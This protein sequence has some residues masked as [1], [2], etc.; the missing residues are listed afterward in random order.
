VQTYNIFD[1]DESGIIN[2]LDAKDMYPQGHGDAWGHY[3][4]GMKIWYR[5]LRHE[6][7]TWE[8][9]V[10]SV[11]V[12][13]APIPV[14]Y[15]DERKFAETAAAK[16]KAGAEIVNLT[17]RLSYVDDPAGQWQGY[18]DTDTE[19]AWGVDGWARR[20]GQGAYFD[21]VVANAMLPAE[22][23]V[24]T[25][26]GITKIDRTTVPELQVLAKEYAVIQSQVDQADQ[27]LNPLGLAKGV[28]PFDIDPVL[29]P[30]IR[31]AK[32]HFEQIYDR[33]M[34]A[35]ENA[36]SVFDY[37]TQYTL[38]LRSNEDALTSFRRGV[39][40]QERDY[41]NRLI[42]IY[43]YPY[44]GDIGPGATYAAGYN[45]PD[46]IH[47]MYVD[48]P[49]LTGEALYGKQVAYTATFNF[50]QMDG[51]DPAFDDELLRLNKS[52]HQE[53]DPNGRWVDIEYHINSDSP[54]LVTPDGWGKR[55]APG[56]IQMAL[57]DLIKAHANYKRGLTEL[58]G[59][60][61]GIQAAVE[62]LEAKH[63]VLVHQIKVKGET[64]D[65]IIG[66][67][68]TL[69]VLFGTRYLME[70]TKNAVSSV[71]D[72]VIAGLPDTLG[73]SMDAMAPVTAATQIAKS[74]GME[75]IKA[76]IDV[77]ALSE[78]GLQVAKEHEIMGRDKKLFIDD[79]R[80]EVQQ[81]VKELECMEGDVRAKIQELYTLREVIQ[82]AMGRYLAVLAEGERLIS[83]RE[84]FRKRT[85]ASVQDYRYQDL[86]FRVFRNDA[87]Q[88]YR[89]TFDL[90]ARYAY[91]AATA[92]DYETN[93]LGWD[94]GSGQGFLTDIVRQRSPGVIISGLPVV[95]KRG[96]ADPLARLSQNF[97]VYK[98]QLGFNNPQTETNRFSLRRELFRLRESSDEAW[99]VELE[100]ALVQDL[101]EFP[102]F[103]RFCRPF[104]PDG[105]GP[106]PGIVIPFS[107][108]VIFGYNYFGWPLGSGDSAYDP[109]NF[110]TKVRSVGVWF[111][112]YDTAELAKTPRVYLLPV[113]ADVLRSPSGDG[114]A[115]REWHVVDQ[116]L[117]VPFPIMDFELASE[118]WIPMNDSLSEEFGAI[119]RFSSFRAYPDWEDSSEA[120]AI[121][122][123]TT[124][125][126]RLIG[127]SVW[128]TQWL[129]IIPGGTLLHDPYAGLD[130]FI[131]NVTDIKLFFHTYAYSGY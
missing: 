107:T 23:P 77:I 44:D 112:G 87:V 43:G 131:N 127:R 30:P 58:E 47:Y 94:T 84:M 39:H 83:E 86:G 63:G 101:L 37:A 68:T 6:Y 71:T 11:L 48:L 116:K 75:V 7:Y 128:N 60:I 129:L 89:A 65:A 95:G 57:S 100:N 3:L 8:P 13:G 1:Q 52:V 25:H 91:L 120:D 115:M 81:M 126:S 10:E 31:G 119:R 16:A 5:L 122:A 38:M 50:G 104:A 59:M 40:A 78:R 64:K 97:G 24:K 41:W 49:D 98:G 130:A 20:A 61:G 27:G 9:R 21:W 36:R 102:P 34:G 118:D 17:Y 82:Q 4:T 70:S 74:I 111:T 35:L 2:E 124:E 76:A 42:E 108:E 103:R 80:F 29:I 109:T 67:D 12:G 51:D 85:A 92:Y 14:D 54:W 45:G 88:K 96:L 19:R 113:G 93:L 26:T 117:P 79:A 110:A 114:F 46:W 18:K 28:V 22:D 15:L 99:R 66:Y 121:A 123:E 69:A 32:T 56:E 125:D 62:I 72:A 55:R 90:A 106:Q 73:F 53:N 105:M 33:A